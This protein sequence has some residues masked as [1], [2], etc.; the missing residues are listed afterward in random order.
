L[1]PDTVIED[2]R[3]GWYLLSDGSRLPIQGEDA[4]N[5]EFRLPPSLENGVQPAII[6]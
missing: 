6:F 1:S 4:A 3:M 2:I 5:G